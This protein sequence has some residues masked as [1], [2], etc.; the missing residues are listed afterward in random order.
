MHDYFRHANKR[1]KMISWQVGVT[2]GLQSLAKHI[3]KYGRING[4]K[5]FYFSYMAGETAT[6]SSAT[7]R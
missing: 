7:C 4:N 2:G 6:N 5:Y 3:S 1:R